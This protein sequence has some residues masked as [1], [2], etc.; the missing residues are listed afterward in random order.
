MA[1]SLRNLKNKKVAKKT[2][3]VK[4]FVS[5]KSKKRSLGKTKK[6]KKNKSQKGGHYGMP[7]EYFGRESG[8][9]TGALNQT[10]STGAGNNETWA[11]FNP[12]IEHTM[13]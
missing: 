1:K 7:L 8:R 10:T 11:G 13:F 4:S 12:A 6:S 5:K 9:F 3:K 2:P